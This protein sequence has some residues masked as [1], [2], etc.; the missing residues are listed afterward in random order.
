MC[1]HWREANL[2]PANQFNRSI[3]YAKRKT[4]SL[5]DIDQVCTF[6]E[7]SYPHPITMQRCVDGLMSELSKN[8]K[9]I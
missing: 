7:R 2:N 3:M 5:P 4:E 6:K 8:S 1:T 9:N